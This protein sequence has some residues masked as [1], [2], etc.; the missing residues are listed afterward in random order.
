SSSSAKRLYPLTDAVPHFWRDAVYDPHSCPNVDEMQRTVIF[1]KSDA[2]H[3][4]EDVEQTI[5][6]FN[7]VWEHYFGDR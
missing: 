2:R 5:A 3:T 1:H 6:G 7:K 4:D